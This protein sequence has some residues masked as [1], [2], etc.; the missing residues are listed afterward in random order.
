MKSWRNARFDEIF[1][2]VDRKFLLDDSEHYRCVGVRWYGMGVFVRE[3]LLGAEISR[4]QQWII[5]S[6][7]IVYNK[8]FAWKGAFAI[9]DQSV[10][11]CIVSD[12]FPTYRANVEQVDERWLRYYFRTPLLAQQAEA[13]S[14]GAAAISKLTLNPPQFWEMIMPLP[15]LAEQWRIVARIE[16]LA[17]KIEQAHGLRQQAAGEAEAF[18]GVSLERILR[19]LADTYRSESLIDIVESERGISYGVVLTGAPQDDGVPTLRAG[20]LH[21][22]HV[23]LDNVKRIDPEIEAR[24]RRTRLCGNELL[25][26]IRGGLGEVAICPREMIGGNVSR[27]IAVIPLTDK[28]LPKYGMYVLSA[29][30][31]QRRM[32]A[33]IRGTS[34][35]GINLKDVRMLRIPVPPVSEQHRIVAHLDDLRTR[36]DSVKHLQAETAAEL[37]AMLPSIL[38]KAFKGEL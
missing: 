31:N 13:L 16:E 9:A 36:V 28:V 26:R 32:I 27:E 37:D 7:D 29:P 35:M 4:K 30:P 11:G 38:D 8:L 22:F 15:P 18:F 33:H 6:G 5:Q 20:N 12:K 19:G 10:D 1:E 17:T 21:R 34:Y 25:L 2:R 14:K 3:R 23:N 24:Y